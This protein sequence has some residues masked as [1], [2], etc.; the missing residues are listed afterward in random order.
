MVCIIESLKVFYPWLELNLFSKFDSLNFQHSWLKNVA[1]EKTLHVWQNTKCFLDSFQDF[2]L[3]LIHFLIQTR[4][5]KLEWVLFIECR[6]VNKKRHNDER[7]R[8]GYQIFKPK[9]KI[10]G[11][12][13]FIFHF[14]FLNLV[15]FLFAINYLRK[16]PLESERRVLSKS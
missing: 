7:E 15:T 1:T 8:R 14:W 5:T 13:Q 9:R 11:A 12:K 3:P 2:S 10:I 16:R 6:Y 4:Y